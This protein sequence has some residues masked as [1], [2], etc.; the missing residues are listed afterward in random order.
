MPASKIPSGQIYHR[1]QLYPRFE[2]NGAVTFAPL[3][4]NGYKKLEDNSSGV[5]AG[6]NNNIL[7]CQ[8]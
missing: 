1:R 2:D 5:S 3:F 6:P 8:G 4:T 7:L